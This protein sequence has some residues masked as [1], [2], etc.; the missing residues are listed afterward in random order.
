MFITVRDKEDNLK[1][2]N[3]NHIISVEPHSIKKYKI[4]EPDTLCTKITSVGAMIS[5]TIVY[6]SVEKIGELIKSA[7]GA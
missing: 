4:G 3:V 5:T 6:D 7:Y 2:L 1:L